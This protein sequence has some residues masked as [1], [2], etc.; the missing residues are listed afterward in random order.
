M[1]MRPKS[2]MQIHKLK[3]KDNKIAILQYQVDEQN[4]IIEKLRK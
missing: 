4:R 1:E 2:D 3:Q